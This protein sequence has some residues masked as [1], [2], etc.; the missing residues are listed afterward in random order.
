MADVN[1][2]EQPIDE[3]VKLSIYLF[4]SLYMSS[5]NFHLPITQPDVG[6][7]IIDETLAKDCTKD[8]QIAGWTL[9]HLPK[10]V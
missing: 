2:S 9:R 3:F 8:L 1:L 10:I 6:N 4:V 5:K 7:I